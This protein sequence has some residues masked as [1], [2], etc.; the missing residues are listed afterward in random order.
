MNINESLPSVGLVGR[1]GKEI[2]R[3]FLR[4]AGGKASCYHITDRQIKG[5]PVN[6]LVA[7][8]AS[9]VL[10]NIVPKLGRNDYLIV[11][12]DDKDIFPLLSQSKATL[13]TYGFNGKACITA[14]SV[15]EDA[16][17]VCIQRAFQSMDGEEKLP[18]EFQAKVRTQENSDSVLAA[19][20]AFAVCGI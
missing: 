10:A 6:V 2:A 11:N 16:L 5:P 19:A 1:S 14:S 3:V 4:M 9:P 13:V 18:Q 8:E 15:T 7:A 17:Q 12:S 20:A